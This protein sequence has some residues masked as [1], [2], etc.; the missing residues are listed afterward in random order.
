MKQKRKSGARPKSGP[1]G[2]LWRST[3]A[4]ILTMAALC[5]VLAALIQGGVLPQQVLSGAGQAAAALGVLTAGLCCAAM[6]SEQRLLWT[7]VCCGGLLLGLLLGSI[8]SSEPLHLPLAGLA[9]AVLALT[10]AA[11]RAAR[12]KRRAAR[13]K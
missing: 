10:A 8:L 7:A 2:W 3:A 6:A 11:L 1:A 9:G 12:P 13:R 4:G 5:A